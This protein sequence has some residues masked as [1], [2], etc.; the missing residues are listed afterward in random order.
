MGAFVVF[1]RVFILLGGFRLS[2]CAGLPARRFC[3]L[4]GT[5]GA[6]TPP[7]TTGKKRLRESGE[8][9]MN[10]FV[11]LLL[12]ALGLIAVFYLIVFITAWL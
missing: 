12:G 7:G 3:F 5:P 6:E 10:I 8:K 11:K 4:I 2:R 1:V 9:Q